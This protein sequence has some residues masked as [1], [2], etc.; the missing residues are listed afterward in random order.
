MFFADPV[1][2]FANIGAAL[3]PGGRLVM[4]IGRHASGCGSSWRSMTPAAACTSAHAPG[5]SPPAARDRN[6]CGHGLSLGG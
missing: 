4:L 2:A 3:R 1:A 5:S 6:I